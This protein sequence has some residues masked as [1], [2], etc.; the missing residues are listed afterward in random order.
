MEYFYGSI[1]TPFSNVRNVYIQKLHATGN[2]VFARI[3]LKINTYNNLDTTQIT[4][5]KNA[6]ETAIFTFDQLRL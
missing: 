3:I 5:S 2:V 4:S 6:T 1:F